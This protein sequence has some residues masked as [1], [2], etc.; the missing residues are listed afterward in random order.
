MSSGVPVVVLDTMVVVSAI[1]GSPRGS[2]AAVLD[3]VATGGV[4]LVISDEP[5]S[6]I[7]RV[8]AILPSREE[9]PSR[10]ESSRSPSTSA[11]WGSCAIPRRLDWPSLPDPKDAWVL[12]LAHD[13]NADHIVTHDRPLTTTAKRLGFDVKTPANLLRELRKGTPSTEP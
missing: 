8:L 12:D 7:V 5:L 9:W 13:S 1:V 2:S 10:R 11:I 3:H 6:E 4:K